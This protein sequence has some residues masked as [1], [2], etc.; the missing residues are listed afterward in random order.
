MARYVPKYISPKQAAEDR[1]RLKT[2]LFWIA[3][4]LPV[5]F[6][7]LAFGYSDQAPAAMRSTIIGLDRLLGFPF[8]ALLSTITGR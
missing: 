1:A 6:A 2:R 3:V 4:S 5:A 7:L 8:A